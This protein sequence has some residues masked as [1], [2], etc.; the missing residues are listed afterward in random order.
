MAKVHKLDKYGDIGKL[1]SNT[2]APTQASGVVGGSY[3][4]IIPF[5]HLEFRNAFTKWVVMDDVKHRKAASKNLRRLFKI[6]NIEAV[7]A[8]PT[9]HI[10]SEAWI[11]EMFNY[12]EPAII[13]DVAEAQSRISVSFDGWGSRREKISVVAIVLHYVNKRGQIVTV[14]AGLPELP[15][16]GKSGV[17]M[18]P[19]TAC[20]IL[21]LI[22]CRSSCS[23]STSPATIWNRRA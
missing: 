7:N 16:H 8:L 14:L 11:G 15:G 2:E 5:R 9:S 12:F 20:C 22:F 4:K 13:Q 6:A 3:E 23:Y 21:L 17:G 18:Y 10:T 19:L 1:P